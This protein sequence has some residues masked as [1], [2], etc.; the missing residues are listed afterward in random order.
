MSRETEKY[1][2]GDGR[3]ELEVEFAFPAGQRVRHWDNVEREPHFSKFYL[4]E[5]GYEAACMHAGGLGVQ[6]DQGPPQ[7]VYDA[8]SD[9]EAADR[10]PGIA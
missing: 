3:Y 4:C 2:A 5:N 9:E 10:G 8:A 7:Y 6:V 1:T